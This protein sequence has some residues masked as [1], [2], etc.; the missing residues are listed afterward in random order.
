L[1]AKF[2]KRSQRDYFTN[3]AIKEDEWLRFQ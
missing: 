1:G 2:K 3:I